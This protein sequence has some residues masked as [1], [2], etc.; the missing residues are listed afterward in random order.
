MY[1]TALNISKDEKKA[2]KLSNRIMCMNDVPFL[3][4]NSQVFFNY[5]L[6]FLIIYN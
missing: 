2:I 5:F 4:K 1:V 6:F 3:K